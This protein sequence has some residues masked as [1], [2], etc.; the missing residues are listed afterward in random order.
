MSPEESAARVPKVTCC[1]SNSA[2]SRS[3]RSHLTWT[4]ICFHTMIQSTGKRTPV[5][6]DKLNQRFHR[7]QMDRP[8]SSSK[9]LSSRGSMSTQGSI[10][11]F[12]AAPSPR[13]T[14]FVPSSAYL[15]TRRVFPHPCPDPA[16]S[17]ESCDS[18]CTYTFNH[19]HLVFAV[20]PT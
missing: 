10:S 2:E 9:H 12:L 8:S 1:F 11:T 13:T 6:I 3:D 19:L 14:G 18:R 17:V 4:S 7:R 15:S 5:L 20:L 16:S